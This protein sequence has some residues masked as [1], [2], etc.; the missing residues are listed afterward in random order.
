LRAVLDQRYQAKNDPANLKFQLEATTI[1]EEYQ[2][3][4]DGL[5]HCALFNDSHDGR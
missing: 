5:N 1:N 4:E 2:I 3:A